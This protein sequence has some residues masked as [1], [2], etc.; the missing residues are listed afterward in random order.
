MG[1]IKDD[2]ALIAQYRAMA[3]F[4][5]VDTAIDEISNEIQKHKMYQFETEPPGPWGPETYPSP[6]TPSLKAIYKHPPS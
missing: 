2:Q 4:P 5:E 3:L 6:I 1:S